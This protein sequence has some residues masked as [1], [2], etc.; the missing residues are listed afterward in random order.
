VYIATIYEA[1]VTDVGAQVM[2]AMHD[3]DDNA[4]YATLGY[5]NNRDEW[6]WSVILYEV[7]RD[8]KAQWGWTD[9]QFA[10]AL[11]IV[12]LHEVGHQFELD[13]PSAPGAFPDYLMSVPGSD[14][15]EKDVWKLPNRFSP[16]EADTIRK[17]GGH[18]QPQR[19]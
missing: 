15:N 1:N 3:N 8:V 5:T 11:R 7:M 14:A 18:N 10:T 6:N 9:E 17:H 13:H 12:A 4:E 16:T 2:S 19:P